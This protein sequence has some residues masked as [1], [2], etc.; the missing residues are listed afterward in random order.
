MARGLT[1]FDPRALQELRWRHSRADGRKGLTAAELASLAGAT[2]SQ[3]VAYENGRTVP[4]P[5]RV[6]ALAKALDVPPAALMRSDRR[7]AWVVADLRRAAALTA[8]EAGAGLGVTPKVWRRFEQQGIVPAQKPAFLDRA[9]CLFGVEKSLLDRAIDKIPAVL[10]RRERVAE[11]MRALVERYVH[12]DETWGLPVKDPCIEEIAALYGRSTAR[13]RALLAYELGQLRQLAVLIQREIVVARYDTSAS[14]Q[15]RAA[16]TIGHH[17][18]RFDRAM[19]VIPGRLENFHRMEQ[20]SDVWQVLVDLHDVNEEMD[21]RPWTPMW[22]LAG[23][24]TTRHLPESLVQ[25]HQFQDMAAL[26]LTARGLS[27]VRGYRHLYAALHPAVRRPL[28]AR[29]H[30]TGAAGG[31]MPAERTF[32]LPGFSERFAVPRPAVQQLLEE[33]EDHGVGEAPISPSTVL[34]LGPSAPGASSRPRPRAESACMPAGAGVCLQPGG[35]AD[36][37]EVEEPAPSRDWKVF[38]LRHPDTAAAVTRAMAAGSGN[39]ALDKARLAHKVVQFLEQ[40]RVGVT[41]KQI[42]AAI[43]LSASAMA[44]IMAML[45]EEEFAL[46]VA[47]NVYGPGPALDRL[48]SPGGLSLQL[49]HTLDLARDTVGAAVYLSRYAEGE[50]VITQVAD[51]PLAPRVNEWV[52]FRYAAHASAVGKCLLTQLPHDLREDHLA[53]HGTARLTRHTITNRERLNHTLDGI[54]P[55]QP[56][57]DVREYASKIVCGA[58][59]ASTEQE[60]G[61]LAVSMPASKA[62]RLKAATETLGRKVV[63]VLLALLISGSLPPSAPGEVNPEDTEPAGSAITTAGLRQLRAVFRT[64][65]TNTEDISRVAHSPRPGPHLAADSNGTSLYLFEAAT[66]PMGERHLTLPHTYIAHPAL[67]ATGFSS[68]EDRTWDGHTTPDRLLIWDSQYAA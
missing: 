64:P 43:G 44:P 51:G 45:C 40:H 39:H 47:S 35:G 4:D 21:E 5:K 16:K 53:R 20:P 41:A 49:Q 28:P 31:R 19:R 36:G 1:D 15:R 30:T 55:G 60:A 56:V 63:P 37:T 18:K 68:T 7:R 27:H 46:A 14:R 33:A 59:A 42:A 52:D 38:Q 67:N 12:S 24:E 32:T 62:H 17:G 2:K 50:V 65:L 3:I 29:E 25:R 8:A 6:A 66:Q 54:A 9:A 48:S 61:S 57:Y 10:E 13:T 58:V 11:L 23:V 26:R 22:L 34:V